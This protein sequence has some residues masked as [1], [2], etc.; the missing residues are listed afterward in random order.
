VK[1]FFRWSERARADLRAIDPQ[2]AR[3]ILDALARYARTD[4][5]DVTALRGR[6]FGQYRL[7]VGPWRVRFRPIQ[8]D[9]FDVLAIE[10]RGDAYR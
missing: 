2:N 7:R 3:R 9:S 10:K 1:T 8:P 5:G 4:I 6:F